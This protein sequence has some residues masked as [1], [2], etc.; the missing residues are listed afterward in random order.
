MNSDGTETN[1]R[2]IAVISD[3]NNCESAIFEVPPTVTLTVFGG[4]QSIEI[5]F[6]TIY[7]DLCEFDLFATPDDFDVQL[8]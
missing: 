7:G 4:P 5:V 2:S 6:K 3:T 8:I 1:I